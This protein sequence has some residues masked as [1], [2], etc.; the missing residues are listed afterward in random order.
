MNNKLNLSKFIMMM[1]NEIVN[2]FNLTQLIRNQID[3]MK[4]YKLKYRITELDIS[5]NL[6]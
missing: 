1:I 5:S 3:I 6:N 4:Y 2:Q